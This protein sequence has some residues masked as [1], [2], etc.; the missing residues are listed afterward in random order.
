[1]TI[2]KWP[3]Q[4]PF[5]VQ[6]GMELRLG[7]EGSKVITDFDYGPKKR[8][9]RF[10]NNP[11]ET[12]VTLVFNDN[13]F[14]DFKHFY[15]T[16][17]FEGTSSFIAPIVT[18]RSI[19]EKRVTIVEAV[20]PAQA[21]SWNRWVVPFTL[22]IRDFITLDATASYILATYGSE[23]FEKTNDTLNR[24]LYKWMESFSN[25]GLDQ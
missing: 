15:Y 18:G 22:E 13:Q 23:L 25:I 9:R 10:T 21:E 7:N 20:I 12:A 6:Y 3:S 2:P 11:S 16:T 1:V 4:L 19:E 5:S 17:L 8:R 24:G 14:E